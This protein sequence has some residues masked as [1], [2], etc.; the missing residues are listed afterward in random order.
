MCVAETQLAA[1]VLTFQDAADLGLQCDGD[2][3]T[4]QLPNESEAMDSSRML[5][6][7]HQDADVKIAK[8]T[9][10]TVSVLSF[11]GNSPDRL[12]Q[13]TPTANR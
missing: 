8:A 10:G 12:A 11:F 5:E 7:P 13:A 6:I 2:P 3:C 4:D 1:A 9:R